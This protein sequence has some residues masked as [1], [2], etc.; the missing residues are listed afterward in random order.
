M[1]ME[2]VDL[3]AVSGS[4]VKAVAPSTA[5]SLPSRPRPSTR[6]QEFTT[7]DEVARLSTRREL[8]LESGH[9]DVDES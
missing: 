3:N 2:L 9:G 8:D 6:T 4:G 1:S 7:A 5:T